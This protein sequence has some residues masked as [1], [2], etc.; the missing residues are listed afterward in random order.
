MTIEEI[1]KNWLKENLPQIQLIEWG[2]KARGIKSKFFNTRNNREFEYEFS[3]LKSDLK[4]FPNIEFGL[5]K[6]ERNEKRRKTNLEKYGTKSPLQ[7]KEIKQKQEQTCLKKY[8]FKNV[9]QNRQ[10]RNKAEK[11]NLKKYGFKYALQ[12]KEI[13]QKQEQTCLKRYGVKSVSQNSEIKKKQ[14]ET[15]LKKYGVL[16]PRQN[17][18]IVEKGKIS[19]LKKYGY[20]W[21][22]QNDQVKQTRVKTNIEK[23][24]SKSPAG[25]KRVQ[26]K[27]KQTRIKKG[28]TFSIDGKTLSQLAQEKDVAYS[29]LQGLYLKTKNQ[30]LIKSYSK[31]YTSIELAVK[32][33]LDEL[34]IKYIH[35]KKLGSYRPDFLIESHKLIIECDGLYWHSEIVQSDKDYH[36]TKKLFYESKGYKSLFFRENE[37]NSKLD[38]V[39]SII[40]N[41]LGLS[42]KIYARKCTFKTVSSKNLIQENHLMGKGSGRTYSLIQDDHTVCLIQVKWKNKSNK[43]LEISRFCPIKGFNVVGGF[44]KLVKNIIDVEKPNSIITFID[45]RYGDGSYLSNL[46]WKKKSEHISFSWIKDDICVHR[47]NFPGNSGYNAEFIKLYDAG[48]AKWQL[49][50]I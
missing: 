50:V 31:K 11:T 48:Q 45:R 37:I 5:S 28:L 49:E 19:N 40:K 1:V 27:I 14:K 30:N 10:I 20:E 29:T 22:I 41:K 9:S 23:F 26:N 6:E 46:G 18:K 36:K 47:M 2:G 3:A 7:N 44:S 24:G 25:N 38:I 4:R 33:I 12:N 34:G 32:L 21:A 13:K 39:K 43:Q 17:K 15:C 42:K 8:G 35:N 16:Y